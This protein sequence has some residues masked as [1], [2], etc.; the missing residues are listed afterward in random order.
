[1]SE[2]WN[3]NALASSLRWATLTR[4]QKAELAWRARH[5]EEVIR[6][7]RVLPGQYRYEQVDAAITAADVMPMDIYESLAANRH[8]IALARFYEALNGP[9]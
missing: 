3:L 4:T 8:I 6:V 5:Q 7:M 1:M 9:E 2:K